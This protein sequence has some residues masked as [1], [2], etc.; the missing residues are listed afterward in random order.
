MTAATLQ[1]EA[2]QTIQ[3]ALRPFG[4]ESSFIQFGWRVSN[5]ELVKR[6]TDQ[7]AKNPK[8]RPSWRPTKTRRLGLLR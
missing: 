8:S 7:E 4:Y 5:V 1:Q 6:Y 3:D 2:R